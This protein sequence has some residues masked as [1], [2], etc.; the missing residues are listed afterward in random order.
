M[1]SVI[2]A[3]FYLFLTAMAVVAVETRVSMEAD[4]VSPRVASKNWIM[5]ARTPGTVKLRFTAALRI[6]PENAHI[7]DRV[8]HEV[9]DPDHERYGQHWSRAEVSAL[10]TPAPHHMLAFRKFF[11]KHGPSHALS[12]EGELA[13]FELTASQAE[14]FFNTEF[15]EFRHRSRA[16]VVLHRAPK[17]Y[18]FPTEVA[19]AVL[20]VDGVVRLPHLRATPKLTKS[21]VGEPFPAGTCGGKCSGHVTPAI[22]TERYKLGDAPAKNSISNRSSMAV[23]EFQDQ[24]WDQQ[25]CNKL[26]EACKTENITVEKQ[27][28]GPPYGGPSAEALLDIQYIKSLGGAIPLT[29]VYSEPYSLLHWAQTLSAMEDPPLV[30]SVSYGNDEAQQT[31]IGYMESCNTQFKALGVRGLSIL[32]ASGD[33]GVCGREGCGIFTTHFHPGFPAASP[34]VTSVGGTNFAT[35][36]VIGNETA[37]KG[38]GGGFSNTFGIPSWQADA[39]AAYKSDCPN[40]PPAKAWNNTG[41]GFPDIAALGGDVNT[42]CIVMEGSFSGVDGTSAATPVTAAVFAKLNDI[43]FKAGKPSLGFLNPFIYKN[44][45]A[46]NDVTT[47]CNNGGSKYGFTAA[48][49]WDPATGWGTPNFEL[50]SR[51]V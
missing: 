43:R 33:Q 21:L 2:F 12:T 11:L 38:S 31:G 42:Y 49:G 36:S 45:K 40:C 3:I 17:G 25:D 34:Y 19:D 15:F 18:S 13:T 9:S 5:G 37:W 35:K 6:K 29:N 22:L 14:A 7:L 28:G 26:A 41:R 8:F 10:L 27:V 44:S 50:L 46:F 20:S 4:V 24:G 1:G 47:G 51:L 48:E 16:G 39:V 23:A 30:N 32:F